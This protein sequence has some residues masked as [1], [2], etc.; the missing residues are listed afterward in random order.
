LRGGVQRAAPNQPTGPQM[1]RKPQNIQRGPVPRKDIRA[2][3]ETYHL[4]LFSFLYVII[5]FFSFSFSFSFFSFLRFR[6]I[7]RQYLDT[8]FSASPFHVEDMI[9]YFRHLL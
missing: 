1:L 4:L 6:L 3:R 9:Q 5:L 2:E 7:L 8:L